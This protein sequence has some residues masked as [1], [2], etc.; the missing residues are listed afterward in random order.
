MSSDKLANTSV[1]SEASS[2]QSEQEMNDLSLSPGPL[3]NQQ[4]TDFLRS[5]K[6]RKKPEHIARKFTSDLPGLVKQMKPLRNSPLLNRNMQMRIRKLIKCLDP[7][8]TSQL[9]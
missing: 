1:A 2:L 5:V 4:M 8:D 9:F 3:S 6:A 7:A